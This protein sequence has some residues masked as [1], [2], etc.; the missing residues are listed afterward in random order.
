MLLIDE[1]EVCVVVDVDDYYEIYTL[2]VDLVVDNS[3]NNRH[4]LHNMD[5]MLV[6]I[7]VRMFADCIER[8]VNFLA[9]I[10]FVVYVV[11]DYF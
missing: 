3:K 10:D 11:D 1:F 6:D 5:P 4:N 7:V 2:L 8:L 9:W